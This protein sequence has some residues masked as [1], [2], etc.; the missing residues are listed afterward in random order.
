[1][2]RI[3]FFSAALLLALVASSC[4]SGDKTFVADPDYELGQSSP[5]QPA[6]SAPLAVPSTHEAE[7]VAPD[8]N[9]TLES[10]C[11]ASEPIALFDGESFAGW[12]DEAGGEPQGWVAEGGVLKIVDPANAR[13]I[14]TAD[15]YANYAFSFE[16]RF[17]RACNSGVKYKIV[18]PNGKGWL[19]LEYQVQDDANVEDGQVPDRR[20]AS[21][22]DVLPAAESSAAAQYPAPTDPAPSGEF[23]SGKIVVVGNRVE[24]WLDDQRVLAFTI[25]S[26]DWNAAKS[27]SKFKNHKD[28]GIVES[29]PILLQAH[30]YPVEFRNL[31]IR[32]LS[33]RGN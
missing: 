9:A 24:H 11:D 30:G 2:Q 16:W 22:F 8:Q 14:V 3:V 19:G 4:N 26:E 32:T 27:D 7:N 21:L 20:I 25:G 1:M 12:T 6:D 29:S 31:E 15:S 10:L 18:Q 28:F 23:R 13:D 33:P 5:S 17:G